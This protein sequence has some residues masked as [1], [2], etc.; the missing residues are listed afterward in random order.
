[1]P[2][3]SDFRPP[4]P[5][6]TP[7]SNRVL[8]EHL[9]KDAEG[10]VR[11]QQEFAI[12]GLR[13]LLLI[14]GGAIIGLLTYAGNSSAERGAASLDIAFIWYV[15]ALV[16]TIM[17]YLFAYLS[18][19]AFMNATVFSAMRQLELDPGEEGSVENTKCLAKRGNIAIGFA[20]ALVVASLVGFIVGSFEA[21][22][23]LG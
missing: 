10:R 13:A 16:A 18:Q 22:S 11:Y 2:N 20:I 3:A 17:A 21:M 4:A 1:M 19:G 15:L 12:A 5:T 7:P 14:N 23:A 9:L 6:A 8:G